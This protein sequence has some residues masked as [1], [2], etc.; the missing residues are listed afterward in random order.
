[1]LSASD[2]YVMHSLVQTPAVCIRLLSFSSTDFRRGSK[3][4]RTGQTSLVGCKK[5]TSVIKESIPPL[6][7]LDTMVH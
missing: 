7:S 1:M 6:N 3:P 4:N 5:G 2:N